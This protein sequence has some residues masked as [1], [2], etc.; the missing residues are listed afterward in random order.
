MRLA[1]HRHLVLVTLLLSNSAA[2]EALP[3]FLDRLTKAYIAVIISV[4][5]VL[6]FGEVR[7]LCHYYTQPHQILPSAI[8]T[9]YGLAIG[10]HMRYVVWTLVVLSFPLAWPVAKCLDWMLGA[11]HNTYES[12]WMSRS[13]SDL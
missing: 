5:I 2:M 11:E 12:I 13:L 6:M 1:R 9:R 10:Y 3:L 8:C 7:M 4:T